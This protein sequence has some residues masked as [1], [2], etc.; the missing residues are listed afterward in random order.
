M[1]CKDYYVRGCTALL[2]AVGKAIQHIGN[3]HK[4]AREEDRPEKTIFVITT[5]GM[6]NASRQY[7][8]KDLKRLIERQRE[9]TA[10]SFCSW[11]PTLM[12]PKKLPGLASMQTGR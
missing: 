7:S 9:N 4:H 12:L 6:E 3:V 11:V 8:Y 2:D 5:D 10:G 1:T